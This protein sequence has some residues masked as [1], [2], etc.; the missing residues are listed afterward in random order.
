MLGT[1]SKHGIILGL[2]GPVCAGKSEVSRRLKD[3]GA[4]IYE[5]DAVVRQL[6]ERADVKQAVRETFGDDVFDA[7]G[8]VNRGA[9]AAKIFGAYGDPELRRSLTEEILFPR[10]GQVLESK[11][12]DFR[13]RAGPRDVL[14][15][16]APTLFEAGRAGWC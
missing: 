1:R 16:D 14:V 15:L 5:A 7:S 6:Y 11:I 4:E 8:Q 2:V 10:T 9:I 12:A 3:R 13:A